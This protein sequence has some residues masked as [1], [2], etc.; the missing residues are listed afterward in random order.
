MIRVSQKELETLEHDICEMI[1]KHGYFRI[2]TTWNYIPQI[3]SAAR[4][5]GFPICSEMFALD[6]DFP[7]GVWQIPYREWICTYRGTIIVIY[8]YRQ[9][10]LLPPIYF[11]KDMK[12]LYQLGHFPE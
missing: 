4:R 1:S 12:R 3:L 10:T 9:H 2:R 8:S 6:V 5:I 11:P 7:N